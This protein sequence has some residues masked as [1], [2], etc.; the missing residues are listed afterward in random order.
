MDFDLISFLLYEFVFC[1][2]G[3]LG[4]CSVCGCVFLGLIV[5]LITCMVVGMLLRFF[6]LVRFA[7]FCWID[8]VL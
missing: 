1:D 2:F 6:V 5:R 3:N 7:V 8:C 4:W